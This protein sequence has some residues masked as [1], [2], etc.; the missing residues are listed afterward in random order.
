MHNVYR[1]CII[2]KNTCTKYAQQMHR[3]KL[4]CLSCTILQKFYV[5]N[6]KPRVLFFTQ[7]QHFSLGFLLALVGMLT[8]GTFLCYYIVWVVFE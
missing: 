2:H 5:R 3:A 6:E 7:E 1:T 4:Y 8:A